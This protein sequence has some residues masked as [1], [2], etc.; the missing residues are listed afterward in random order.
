M[1]TR[2]STVE[3]SGSLVRGTGS[4]TL[5]SSKQRTFEYSLQTRAADVASGTSPEELLAAA[6]ASCYAMQL[7]ALL[8]PGPDE[9]PRLHVEVAVTQGGPEVDF[10]IAG[11]ALRVRGTDIELPAARFDEL[12]HDASRLCPI[13]RALSA[14]PVSIDAG[15]SG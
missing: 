5:S 7:S 9:N 12:A 6:Y 13:G 2:T 11:I 14:V 4:I 3:W 8:D 10:G 1:S 15:F